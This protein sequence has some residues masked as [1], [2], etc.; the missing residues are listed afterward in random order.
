MHSIYTRIVMLIAHRI[1]TLEA[2]KALQPDTPIEFDVRESD[3]EC[4]VRHDAFKP[5]SSLVKFLPYLKTRF[6]IVNIKCEGIE[7]YILNLFK[8]YEIE[9][10]IFL[11]CSIPMIHKLTQQGESRIAVRWSEYESLESVL[12]WAGKVQWIWVDCFTKYP[13]TKQTFDQVC[14]LGFKLCLVSPELQGRCH[15][16]EPYCTMLLENSIHPHAICTKLHNFHC[17]S[18]LYSDDTPPSQMSEAT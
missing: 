18:K 2:L 3:Y 11:D 16:I 6:C 10:F 8:L 12:S 17:W 9:N 14:N 1:N 5:G 4:S 15:D 7:H 13:L